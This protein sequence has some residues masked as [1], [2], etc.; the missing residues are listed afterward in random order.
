M[1]DD[2]TL[3]RRLSL[4]EPI[5]RMIPAYDRTQIFIQH[6]PWLCIQNSDLNNVVFWVHNYCG[7]PWFQLIFHRVRIIFNW[8]VAL[9][10]ELVLDCYFN[11]NVTRQTTK[12]DKISEFWF[13]LMFWQCCDD[14][15]NYGRYPFWS[16]I[17][18]CSLTSTGISCAKNDTKTLL[19]RCGGVRESHRNH[20]KLDC[21][22]SIA[23][24]G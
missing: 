1:E 10:K 15:I 11:Q 8:C 19:Y 23:H 16:W 2:Y 5:H 12:R 18:Y 24:S 3:W 20:L 4:A 9:T 22:F 21:L 13:W 6:Q 7:V 17:F 14:N